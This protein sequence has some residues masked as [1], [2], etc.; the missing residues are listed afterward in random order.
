MLARPRGAPAAMRDPITAG[1]D[2]GIISAL[3]ERLRE[4]GF[5]TP[6]D[7][8]RQLGVSEALVGAIIADLERRGYLRAVTASCTAGC[9]G[10]PLR[11]SCVLGGVG[12]GW[13]LTSPDDHPA[14]TRPAL[15]SPGDRPP[16][17]D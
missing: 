4:G 12:R 9:S 13:M 6:A 14:A 8:A 16:S 7:L 15:T 5:R 1:G 11:G 3:L 2:Q 17:T 10:C